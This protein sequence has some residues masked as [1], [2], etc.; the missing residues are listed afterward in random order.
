MLQ[1]TREKIDK[2]YLAAAIRAFYEAMHP[3]GNTCKYL[4]VHE[5][6]L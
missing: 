6:N 1:S 4:Q 3:A 5:K 2:S